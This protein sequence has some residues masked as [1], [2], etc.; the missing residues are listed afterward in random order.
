M[1]KHL[2][3]TLVGLALVL[4]GC[5][6]AGSS[7]DAGTS[8]NPDAPVDSTSDDP[9]DVGGGALLADTVGK[10]P[11]HI[12]EIEVLVAESFPVQLFLHVIGN[13]PTPCHQVAYLVETEGDQIQVQLT[14][15]A[16]DGMCA[17]VLQPVDVSVPL[18]RAELPVTV[19]VNDGEF[20]T[21]VDS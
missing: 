20:V 21:T 14:T 9:G 11:L 8:G 18:G 4:P 17:Q 15:A 13:A 1:K 6:A 12:D 7:N 19:T 5:G 16:E 2:V 10:S 3:G